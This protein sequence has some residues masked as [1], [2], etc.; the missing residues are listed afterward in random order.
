ML[1]IIAEDEGTST[2]V[3]EVS[4]KIFVRARVSNTRRNG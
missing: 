3:H 2:G 4:E 1:R